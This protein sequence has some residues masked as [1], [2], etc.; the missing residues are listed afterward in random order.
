MTRIRP[1][2]FPQLL[3][4][5]L[6]LSMSLLFAPRPVQGEE[7]I[8][9]AADSRP[10]VQDENQDKNQD[11]DLRSLARDLEKKLDRL[12]EEEVIA[13][14]VS[15]RDPYTGFQLQIKPDRV[16]RS[17]STMKVA[18]MLALFRRAEQ[19][20]ISLNKKIRVRNRFTSAYDKSK[21][22]VPPERR[23]NC[24]CRAYKRLGRSMRLIDL[25]RDMIISSSNLATNLL[26]EYLTPKG[27]SAELKA[28][29]VRGV[30]II[31]GLY[32]MKAYDHNQFNTLTAAGA[33][34][35]FEALNHRKYFTKSSRKTMMALLTY[36]AHRNKLP[37]FLPPG[38]AVAQK[39][40]FTDMVSHDAG[41]I[42]PESGKPYT[43]AILTARHKDGLRVEER[44]ALASRMIYDTIQRLRKRRTRTGMFTHA[45]DHI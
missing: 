15:L 36:T 4:T 32:D 19:K 44:I 27:V 39:S 42:Y 34:S 24:A 11:E 26:L 43:L 16:Y 30:S 1:P 12:F 23:K 7:P 35:L 40:G 5:F 29:N 21:Y 3:T 28:M 25:C 31:R 6:L 8:A 10:T 41:L 37:G 13:Y 18:V 33:R 9:G 17:A 22:R 20:K 14:S 38:V 2:F 45:M